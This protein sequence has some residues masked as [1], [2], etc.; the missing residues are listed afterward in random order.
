MGVA[1]LNKYRVPA[2]AIIF[3]T[4]AAIILAALL[5]IVIPLTASGSNPATLNSIIYNVVISASTLVWAISTAF[6]FVDLAKFY[7]Q[8]RIAFRRQMLFPMPV[9][10]A[11]IIL[12]TTSCVVSIIG[13][14]L[15]SLIPKAMG[16]TQWFYIVGGITVVCLAMAASGS[17]IARS[18]ANWES[19]KE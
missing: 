19:F 2:N 16:N 7:S 4:I 17:M 14:L 10:W 9:L 13:T 5:F 18:E 3:Q 1:R 11:S 12:G 6:L 8:D 15:Y